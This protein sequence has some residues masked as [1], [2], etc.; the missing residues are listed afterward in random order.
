MGL[1]AVVWYQGEQNA[2]CGGPTQV[3][4]GVYVYTRVFGFIV[5]I[6]RKRKAH[7]EIDR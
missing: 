6:E 4:G 5:Y 1:S 7:T 2:N 3:D